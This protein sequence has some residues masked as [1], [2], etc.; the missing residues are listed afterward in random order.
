MT[1]TSSTVL[2]PSSDAY[3]GSEV[4]L[5]TGSAAWQLIDDGGGVVDYTGADDTTYVRVN[6]G[7]QGFTEGRVIVGLTNLL[8]L[9]ADERI[10]QVRLRG[11]VRM[12]VGVAG[13]GATVTATVRDPQSGLGR[14]GS[15]YAEADPPRD[16]WFTSNASSFQAKTGAWR[17]T[18]PP[19]DGAEWTAAI[20]NRSQ[21]EF[22]WYYSDDG[23]GTNTNLRLSEAYLDVDV[24]GRHD[25]PD[26]LLD[27]QPQPRRGPAGP[28]PGQ[29]VHRRPIQR[30]QLRP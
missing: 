13:F 27:L 25:P 21:L 26:D 17:T 3:R 2:R 10:K 9:A 12:N 28:L 14:T 19:N 11:R 5:S 20:V 29:G 23:G 4:V 24:R 18:P 16:E 15:V 30:G 7:H 6:G 22:V 1:V 8:A